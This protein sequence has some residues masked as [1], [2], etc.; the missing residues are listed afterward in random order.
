MPVTHKNR[1]LLRQIAVR[2]RHARKAR[3]MYA[4]PDFVREQVISLGVAVETGQCTNLPGVLESSDD[5][6]I[7]YLEKTHEK[8]MQ[9]ALV[10]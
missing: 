2:L 3:G 10:I 6:L 5:A 1:A 4:K 9:S 8:I 7:Q